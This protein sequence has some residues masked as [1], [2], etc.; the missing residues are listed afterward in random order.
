MY[1]FKVRDDRK[2]IHFHRVDG[3]EDFQFTDGSK[4]PWSSGDT[5]E[6]ADLRKRIEPWLTSLFQSEHLTLLAGSGLTHAVHH[7]AVGIPATAMST[8]PL[9]V[10][11]DE[12][13]RVMKISAGKAGRTEGNFEDQ[14]RV[15]N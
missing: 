3:D 4:A 1:T 10:F 2:P 6:V 13:T 11:N 12:V 9:S 8:A 7:L 5:F 15:V 14:V